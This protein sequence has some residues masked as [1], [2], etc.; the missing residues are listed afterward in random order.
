MGHKR[1][2]FKYVYYIHLNMVVFEKYTTK[3]LKDADALLSEKEQTEQN[4]MVVSNDAYAEL[5]MQEAILKKLEHLRLSG[6]R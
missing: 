6:L 1:Q 4:K 5:E 3:E 2:K